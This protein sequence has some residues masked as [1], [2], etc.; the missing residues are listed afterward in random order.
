[1]KITFGR[2]HSLTDDRFAPRAIRKHTFY[3]IFADVRP[4]DSILFVMEVHPNG[5]FQTFDQRSRG[6]GFRV[7]DSDFS[8]V[9]EYNQWS[10]SCIEEIRKVEGF[11][12]IIN[13]KLPG[14]M[15]VS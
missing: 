5:T 13:S 1:M 6:A 8:V 10:R 3:S 11:S 9:G 14:R 12:K 4:I 7:K 15:V 2:V